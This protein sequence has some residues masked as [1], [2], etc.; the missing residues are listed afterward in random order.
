MV[1]YEAPHKLC[2]TLIDLADC[3]GTDRRIS[4]CRELSKLHEEILRMTL[5]EAIAY[6]E[7][8]PPRGEYVLVLEGA[9]APPPNRRSPWTWVWS[10]VRQ[11]M[12]EGYAPQRRRQTGGQGPGLAKNALYEATW[13]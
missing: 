8:Q 13:K 7:A 9:T 12:S 5:G 3:F 10:G 11:L 2:Q 4:L 1:F 6:Y